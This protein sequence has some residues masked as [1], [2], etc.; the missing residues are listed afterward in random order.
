MYSRDMPAMRNH[1]LASP[2]GLTDVITFVLCTI[3]Q[4]LQ[5]VKRQMADIRANGA[6]SKYLFGSKRMGYQYACDHAEVLHAAVVKAAEV[7][8]VVGAVDVL[9]NVPGLGV[10]KASFVAQIVGLEASCLDTHNLKRL[11]LAESAFKMPKGLKHETRLSKIRA[12]L[13][14]CVKSGGAEYW[15]NSW[16]ET[17][18]GNR[19][20]KSLVSADV[21]S[22]YHA[23]CI[24]AE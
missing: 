3:Q 12:Y 1:A 16:C 19:A 21:V 6:S 5:S 20:N 23:E 7:G 15:W 8:D 10:V 24:A 22:R 9:S 2:E 14:L 11:G 4:P 13:A 17:V 18:A